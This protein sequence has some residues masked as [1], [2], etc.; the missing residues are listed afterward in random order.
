MINILQVIAPITF[1]GAENVLLSIN[2]LIDKSHF[3]PFCCIF[4]NPKRGKNYLHERLKELNC[5][6]SIIY[7]HKKFEINNISDLV[8]IIR[9]KEI[10][11]IHTHSYRSDVI[12]LIAAKIT[13]RPIV[14]TVHGWTSTTG[15]VRVYEY[16]QKKVMRYFDTVIPVSQ[17]INDELIQNRVRKNRLRKIHNII[18]YRNFSDDK[19]SSDLKNK[20]RIDSKTP[21]LGVIGRLSREK[22]HI[23]LLKAITMIRKQYP[24]I[25]LFII[26]DGDQESRLREF[27]KAE[28]MENTVFFCGFQKNVYPFYQL[29]DIFILPSLAEGI[30]LVLLEAMHFKKPIIASNV[31]G[32]PE[33]IEH[34]VT[35]ELIPSG[36][37]MPLANAILKLLRD[38]QYAWQIGENGHKVLLK[39]YSPEG[40]IQEI[41]DVYRTVYE[42]RFI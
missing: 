24:N 33:L 2:S 21:S 41:E 26:G 1:G 19:V 6:V 32:I 16:V 17:Q 11:L 27:V 22:G 7:M 10:H 29:F 40:W 13:K 15:R 20:Y 36:E 30:P 42:K 28:K 38:R 31:G 4:L 35:G 37:P 14:S 8:R 12:G 25:K 34:G 18:N 39:N 9:E 3:S 5:D 23:I